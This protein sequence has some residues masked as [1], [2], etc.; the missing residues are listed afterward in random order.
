MLC[1]R[2]D[3]ETGFQTAF[4]PERLR[5]RRGGKSVSKTVEPVEK[6]ATGPRAVSNGLE[7]AQK[8]PSRYP[9]GAQKGAR[10]SFSTSSVVF[11]IEQEA[12]ASP[13]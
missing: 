3:F 10:R 2:L 9:N 11:G 13:S 1:L 8:R 5:S 4:R 7:N 12:Y 6:V